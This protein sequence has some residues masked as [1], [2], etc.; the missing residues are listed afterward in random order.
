MFRCQDS[1]LGLR[2]KGSGFRGHGAGF[3]VLIYGE[4]GD[5]ETKMRVGCL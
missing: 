2:V 1:H 4:I 5:D 3:R